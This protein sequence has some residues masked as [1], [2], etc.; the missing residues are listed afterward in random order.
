MLTEE[1]ELVAEIVSRYATRMA[2]NGIAI[3]MGE[4]S[5]ELLTWNKTK[6]LNL[7]GLLEASEE[8]IVHD[9]GGIRV[10]WKGSKKI[11]HFQPIFEPI[12][13]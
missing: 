12:Y 8:D 5:I 2:R 4:A 7:W 11:G 13:A 6:P 9:V 3:P 1:E 10:N